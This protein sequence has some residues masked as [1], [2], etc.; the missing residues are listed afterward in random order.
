MAADVWPGSGDSWPYYLT[1]Y[2]GALYF[3]ADGGDGAGRE[4]WKYDGVSASR[5][6]DIWSGPEE[7]V[8]TNLAVYNGALYFSAFDGDNTVR[9]MWRYIS[10]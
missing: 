4:L 7:S 1:V 6:A 2:N 9:E 10:P 3:Q 5:V 8:P